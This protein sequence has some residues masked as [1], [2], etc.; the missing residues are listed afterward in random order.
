MVQH[1]DEFD[2][3]RMLVDALRPFDEDVRTRLLR[4]AEE[5][6]AL[7]KPVKAAA[8]AAAAEPKA[9]RRRGRRKQRAKGRKAMAAPAAVAAA[10][11]AP[12]VTGTP[13]SIQAFMAQ[14]KPRSDVQF[15]AAVA[16]Y[17]RHAAPPGQRKDDINGEDLQRAAQESGRGKF[18]NPNQTLNNTRRL[19]YLDKGKERGSFRINAAGEKLIDTILPQGGGRVRATGARKK[20]PARR[21]A[22]KVAH[23]AA[24]KEK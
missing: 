12:A 15:A 1:S 23:K 8:R 17:F 6:L 7:A 3:L 20:T 16:Y 13:G 10:T 18:Q 4:W 24:A 19:G 5:I 11:P 2:A 21:T 22:R 9:A 14:K